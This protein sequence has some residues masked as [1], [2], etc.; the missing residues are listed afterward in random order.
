MKQK[1]EKKSPAIS[2][3]G[4]DTGGTYTDIILHQAGKLHSIKIP[5]TPNNPADAILKGL[6]KLNLK[7]SMEN[8]L[9]KHGSTVATNAFLEQRGAKIC[10]VTTQGFEDILTIGRQNRSELYNLNIAPPLELVPPAHCF[11]IE[12]RVDFQ[13]EIITP[14]NPQSITEILEKIKNI[15]PEAIAISL[16]FSYKNPYHERQLAKA[17][18]SLNI[19]IYLSSEVLPKYREYERTCITTINAATSPIMEKYL[20]TLGNQ[21]PA[22]TLQI[23]QSNGGVTSYQHASRNAVHTLLSGPAGGV[24]GALNCGIEAGTSKIISFDMGGTSTDVSLIDEEIKTVSNFEINHIPLAIPMIPINTVGAGG[25]SIAWVDSGGLLKVGPES[26]GADPGPVCYGKGE[27]PTVTDAHLVL[28]RLPET[29]FLATG[30][31]VFKERAQTAIKKLANQINLSLTEC[32][33][34]IIEIANSHI[35]NAIRVISSSKGYDPR[36]FSLVTFGGAGG[37]HAAEV[38]SQLGI[39]EIIIPEKSGLLSAFGMI[40]SPITRFYTQT[41]LY[42]FNEE[43][44]KMAFQTLLTSLNSIQEKALK[45]FEQEGIQAHEIRKDPLVEMRYKGQ[46]HELQIPFKENFVE[47]FIHDH[48]KRFGFVHDSKQFQVVNLILKVSKPDISAVS[49]NLK[50]TCLEVSDKSNTPFQI[51]NQVPFYHR[52]QLPLG[53]QLPGPAVILEYGSTTFLPS[54]FSLKVNHQNQLILREQ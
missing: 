44:S 37:L 20:S 53:A 47:L 50:E 45:E 6:K 18:S 31:E 42:T 22:A 32:A 33:E 9:I 7:C 11:G 1:A 4:V 34:G 54:N 16:L 10:L 15:N 48:Q 2:L 43:G 38:A 24:M 29:A 52:E 36:E 30:R 8:H 19:P 14:I 46:S 51:C 21:L 28:G 17:L 35:V 39:K 13:G 27:K 49:E 25:G 3:I 40:Q 5:S 23:M 41:H 26:A 12:E